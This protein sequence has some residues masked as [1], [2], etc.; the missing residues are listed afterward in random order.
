MN[1]IG[2]VSFLSGSAVAIKAD[3]T[4][5]QLMLGDEVYA[6]EM[7]KVS[8]DSAIEIAMEGGDPVRL[9]G[10]QNWL[11]SS[12]TFTEAE[13]FDLSEA[14]T[15]SESIGDAV[16]G[17]ASEGAGQG[18]GADVD[19]IQAAILAGQDPTEVAEATAAGAGGD[20]AGGNEGTSTVVLDRTADE[21]D[22]NAGYDTIGFQD[23]FEQPEEELLGPV[24]EPAPVDEPV[25]SV[26]VQVEVEVEVET[27][28]DLEDPESENPFTG[29][30][31]VVLSPQGVLVLEGTEGEGEQQGA[32]REVTFNLVLS[33]VYD[34]DVEV[35][36]Q[37]NILSNNNAADYGPDWDNGGLVVT[38][39][40]PAGQSYIPVTITI[41]QDRI[42]EANGVFEIVLIDAVNATI[43]PDAN[44]ETIIIVDDDTTPVA[45]D[46]T[47][48]LTDNGEAYT[49]SGNVLDNDTD[50]DGDDGVDLPGNGFLEVVDAP[51]EVP[52]V[53]GSL[54][55]QQDGSYDF[56]LNEAGITYLQG[57]GDEE[58]YI[59]FGDVYQVTDGV[60]DG[61]RADLTITLSGVNDAP[62][63]VDDLFTANEDT[64]V[65][66]TSAGLFDADGVGSNDDYD[67]D[68]SSFTSITV[69]AL[70]TDGTL[71]LDGVD[72]TLN[73]VVS[74]QDIADGKLS[75]V[76]DDDESGVGYATFKYT[77]SDG[78]S[79]SNEATVT[80]DVTPTEDIDFNTEALSVELTETDAAVFAE[81][82]GTVSITD[83]DGSETYNSVVY[84]FDGELDAGVTATGGIL[85][86]VGGN[87]VLTVTVSGGALPVSYGLNF[88]A[89]YSTTGVAGSTTNDGADI[90]FDV[91]VA[92]NEGTDDS[93]GSI[94]IGVE[95]DI[96]VSVGTIAAQDETDSVVTFT[97]SD[98]L[99][100]SET[101]DDTSEQVTEVTVS[102][103]G[104]PSGSDMTGW[105]TGTSAGEYS[106]TGTSTAGVPDVGIAADWSG[107]VSG[108]VAGKTDE[109]GEDSAPFSLTV[110]ATNDDPEIVSTGSVVVSE[111]GLSGGILDNIGNLDT[112]NNAFDGSG[113]VVV[114]DIDGGSPTYTLDTP[115]VGLTSGGIAITWSGNGE[116]TNGL[117]GATQLT[118]SASSATIIV[119]SIAEDGAWSADLQGAID[120]PNKTE[121]DDLSFNVGV[122]VS[123][124]NGGS[125]TA[126]LSITVE[127]DS[128]IASDSDATV[129]NE[130]GTR[131]L[132]NLIE[133]NLG[134][135]GA[136]SV[137]LS[138]ENLT[139]ASG[140]VLAFTTET[141]GGLES[142]IGYIDTDKDNIQDASEMDVLKLSPASG[143]DSQGSYT[144][145][146][147][148][149]LDL[150]P[151]P[152]TV[153]AAQLATGP[154][155][156]VSYG[157]L[158]VY[159]PNWV[160]G[161]GAK[162]G[163][164]F[165]QNDGG[166]GDNI[167]E[168]NG[169][170]QELPL[171]SMGFSWASLVNDVSF[172]VKDMESGSDWTLNWTATR[173]LTEFSGSVTGDG[174]GSTGLISVS[175]G[176]D[177]LEIVASPNESGGDTSVKIG[178]VTYYEAVSSVEEVLNINYVA[179]DGDGDA[180]QGS[181]DITI[182]DGQ[183]TGVDIN[184]DLATLL[185]QT[186]VPDV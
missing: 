130:L 153:T 67:I 83:G 118:G 113:Q 163:V 138:A 73:Q 17:I 75:F 28:V 39:T 3:G 50:A 72:V 156:S 31:N 15:G 145:E 58:A 18:Q 63:A 143:S 61:G 100:V 8:L 80:I 36:Y 88:P 114:T 86:V 91:A 150:T 131:T 52:H 154:V 184:S 186:E 9:D 107:T 160:D 93:S 56:V 158:T 64:A 10:G 179:Q 128:P 149:V 182:G 99:T 124:G 43:N 30:D 144:L 151:Q 108:T 76:P 133:Y 27:E 20:A 84:T 176:F 147:Y 74:A 136:G 23:T 85:S 165:N 181:L 49:V 13:D 123:D 37:F 81:L 168:S 166:I 146:V 38:E 104:V 127:D 167:L 169:T 42:D 159:D 24:E 22:P 71:Q 162:Q 180:V 137:T 122:T 82:A 14:V 103:T 161:S 54:T 95:G 21:V 11:A 97:L 77:V 106:W 1:V 148:D 142:L 152:T 120:H 46:D 102:L 171:E 26:S 98:K 126:T 172:T 53:L 101:D 60:N 47:N 25:V 51:I 12:E 129:K 139:L 65:T 109:G 90:A 132:E 116:G 157:N 112:T 40:I 35:T 121:E 59:T 19:A 68:S 164:N 134:A 5:R 92:T 94:S 34:Q 119:I 66:I 4:E 183:V 69:T 57:L 125:D 41:D 177:T 117:T 45:I 87:S 44:S 174:H 16:S 178:S 79:D 185:D 78:T 7:V 140:D 175:G 89:D 173:G 6:D 105:T 32:T 48:S 111:E 33:E 2:T 115:P 55:I 29:G 155:E 110:N 70:A 141:V 62:V 135:D 96:T 170:G